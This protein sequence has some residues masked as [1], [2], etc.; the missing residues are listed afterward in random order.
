MLLYTISALTQCPLSNHYACSE[1]TV[2]ESIWSLFF[3]FFK[4]WPVFTLLKKCQSAQALPIN[5]N[6]YLA[7]KQSV[8]GLLSRRSAALASKRPE[9][10][11]SSYLSAVAWW[12]PWDLNVLFLLCVF[13]FFPVGSTRLR[14]VE[15]LREPRLHFTDT[16][17]RAFKPRPIK[18]GPGR[19]L[20][21]GTG[22]RS[23]GGFELFMDCFYSQK[24]TQLAACVPFPPRQ[25]RTQLRRTLHSIWLTN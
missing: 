24:C 21:P 12:Q 18:N 13:F 3:F 1:L 20:S 7:A 14:A 5:R 22:C 11:A 15:V 23:T 19:L 9:Q 4:L 10:I 2:V 8:G 25:R 17:A 16:Q 6:L